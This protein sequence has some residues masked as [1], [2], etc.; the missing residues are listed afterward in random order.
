MEVSTPW[1]EV[2]LNICGTNPNDR[3]V[4]ITIRWSHQSPW[5]AIAQVFPRF[6][7]THPLCGGWWG[8]N[9]FWEDLWW[10]KQPLCL[11]YSSLFKVVIPK[12]LPISI[13]LG[14]SP[15]LYHNLNFCNNLTD[16]KITDLKR[17]MS[18]LFRLVPINL[19]NKSLII[20]LFSSFLSH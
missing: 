10:G 6:F 17:L 11:Q 7:Q 19:K 12:N 4:N 15:F 14:I 9:L 2:I 16:S 13:I 1:H 20:I 8:K 18:S 5:K 3:D